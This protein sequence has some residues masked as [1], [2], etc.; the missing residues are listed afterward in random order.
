MW[1]LLS[2]AACHLFFS[3]PRSISSWVGYQVSLIQTEL[4]ILIDRYGDDLTIK[5]T[6]FAVFLQS[7]KYSYYSFFML[8]LLLQL[9]T[10]QRDFGPMLVAER[11]C[12]VYDRTD[13]GPNKGKEGEM[14]GDDENQ[15]RADQPL[16]GYNLTLPVLILVILIFVLLVE[17]GTIPGE[18]Q[19]FMDKIENSDSYDALLWGTM[20]TAWIAL[21][22]Y[23]VQITIPGTGTLVWPTPAVLKDM[24]PWRKTQVGESAPR[25]LMTVHE[26]VEGFL[27]GAQRIFLAIVVLVSAHPLVCIAVE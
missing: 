19:S 26:S 14:D 22:M 9:I 5:N 17:T 23:L 4:D 20:A 1:L 2:L 3:L 8:V 16:M 27:Y 15:P 11:R 6:G 25:S 10:L 21:L 7:I 13:G 18:E 12:R 24:L